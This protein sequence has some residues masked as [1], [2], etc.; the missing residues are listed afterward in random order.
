MKEHHK[1]EGAH[2]RLLVL[3]AADENVRF[4]ADVAW[5][6]ANFSFAVCIVDCVF[7]Y[8]HGIKWVFLFVCVCVGGR[9]IL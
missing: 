4:M 8:L 1:D 5:E 9:G 3:S 2:P 7:W 6:L